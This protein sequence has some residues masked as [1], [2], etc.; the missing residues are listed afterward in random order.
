MTEKF[1]EVPQETTLGMLI[2]LA[3]IQSSEMAVKVSKK[4]LAVK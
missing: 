4:L 3:R 1:T 2:K